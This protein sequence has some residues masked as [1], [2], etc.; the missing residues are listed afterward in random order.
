MET[1]AMRLAPFLL[2]LLVGPV[3]WIIWARPK[4]YDDVG[5]YCLMFDDD[6]DEHHSPAVLSISASDFRASTR[7]KTPL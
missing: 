1:V 7:A 5:H 2:P 3:A 4:K 6:D